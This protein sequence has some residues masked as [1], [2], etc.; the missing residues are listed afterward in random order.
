MQT[1]KKNPRLYV[2]ISAIFAILG[3]TVTNW[4]IVAPGLNILDKFSYVTSSLGLHELVDH[5]FTYLMMFHWW[6]IGVAVIGVILGWFMYLYGNDH[7]IYRV[8]EEHGSARFAKVKEM[9]KYQDKEPDNNIIFTKNAQMGLYNRDLARDVQRN[10]NTVVI[11]GPG[12]GKTFTYVKPNL[13]QMNASYVVTDPKGLLVRETGKMLEDNGYKVKVFDLANL[14]NSDTFNVFNYMNDELDIDRVLE[15]ITEGTKKGDKGGE[16]FWVQAEG[17]LIRAFIGFLWF[18]GRLND[19]T[20]HLGMV[21]DMLRFTERKDPKKPSPVEEWFEELNEKVPNNYAYKQW[22]SFNNNFRSETRT[23]VVAIATAR[24]SVFDHEAVVDM[25]KRDTMNIEAWNEEKTAV[26][27]ALPETSGSYNFLASIFLSTVMETLRYKADQT[28]AGLYKPKNGSL[29]H[30]RF[31][32]DEFANIGK[33]PNVDKALATFRSREMSLTIILQA[34]DQLKT[35][36]SKGWAS[37]INLADTLLFLGGD[38]KETV[39]YLS[40]RAGKQT[41]QLRNHTMQNS[42]RGGS[43]NRQTQGRDLMTPDEI[44]RLQGDKALLFVSKEFVFEDSKYNVTD[45]KNAAQL[46]DG[47]QDSNWY[48]YR[49][50]KDETEELLYMVDPSNVI[51]HGQLET[52]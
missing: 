31:I 6:S 45:H 34:L 30:V 33:I 40:K 2:V 21:A 50:F 44:G 32:L 17:T 5:V 52:I 49:R 3:F 24:Y 11:G 18:D 46:A 25:I 16:D 51:D 4:V 10:K 36:Y 29:L 41:I 26:F 8:G 35:M 27:I 15:A 19:Y 28:L 48:K 9:K 14:A 20:P 12:S 37:M 1:Y 22:Q 42:N 13:M 47:P 38:E 7:G 23:S 39:E 43:E